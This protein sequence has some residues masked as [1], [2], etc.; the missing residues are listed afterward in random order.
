MG[1]IFFIALAVSMVVILFVDMDSKCRKCGK[2]LTPCGYYGEK[3]RCDH[4]DK[5]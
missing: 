4:C 2:T 3:S 5:W 1:L